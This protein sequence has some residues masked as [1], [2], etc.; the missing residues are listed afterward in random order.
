MVFLGPKALSQKNGLTNNMTNSRI[1]FL[2]IETKPA[3]AYV[4]R[5]Y[6]ENVGLEQLIEA[7]GVICFG[8]QW[9]GEKETIFFSEWEHGRDAMI[10][11]AH[12]LLTEA[13]AVVTYNGDK[14]DLPKLLG[15]FVLLGLAPPPSSYEH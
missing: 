14:F 3:I 12:A 15:E 1:L 13:D 6:D 9:L 11:A 10:Q 5:L 2:D 8:A 7:G 4:W